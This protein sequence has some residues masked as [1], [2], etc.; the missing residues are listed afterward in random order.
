[1]LLV[2]FNDGQPTTNDGEGLYDAT[3]LQDANIP[4]KCKHHG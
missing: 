3:S 1:M 4:A 2:R